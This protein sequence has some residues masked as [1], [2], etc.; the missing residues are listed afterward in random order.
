MKSLFRR[1]RM[2][3]DFCPH[4]GCH[5]GRFIIQALGMCPQCDAIEWEW[6]QKYYS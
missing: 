6:S 1:F 4:C 2:W 3:I 5:A